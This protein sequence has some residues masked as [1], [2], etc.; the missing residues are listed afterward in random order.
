MPALA[1]PVTVVCV[2]LAWWI[3]RRVRGFLPDDLPHPGRKQHLRPVPLA[4]I[5]LLPVLSWWLL[6]GGRYVLA[7]AVALVAV[8]GYLDDWRK[9]RGGEFGWR[10]KALALGIAAAATASTAFDPRQEPGLWLAACACAF[11]LTNAANFLDNSDGVTASVTGI[12]LLLASG[13]EGALAA[14]GFAALGFLPWNW[15]RPVLFLG[16]AGAYALGLC[17]GAACAERLPDLRALLPFAL[18]FADFLQVVAARLCLGHPPWVGDRRHLTHVAMNL[19]LPPR[20]VAPVF[21][22]TV[23]LVAFAF[24]R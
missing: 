7:G 22:A 2:A 10:K 13:G 19:G 12:G 8:V 3:N 18:L 5:A 21:A 4:G 11:V 16:D 23:A 6:D 20:W 14:C 15:P 17:A 1:L 24:Q 9:E